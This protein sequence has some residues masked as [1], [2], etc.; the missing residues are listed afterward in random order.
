MEE[1]KYMLQ[2]GVKCIWINTFETNK[3]IDEIKSMTLDLKKAFP[4][5]EYSF[6]LG[7]RKVNMIKSKIIPY[8]EYNAVNLLKHIYELSSGIEKKED[9]L[10]FGGDVSD[11]DKLF[12]NKN[13]IIILKDFNIIIDL[14][15]VK[16]IMKDIF[17]LEGG[18]Y[19]PLIIIS[20]VTKIPDELEKFISVVDYELPNDN[21]I[22]SILESLI[23]TLNNKNNN[24]NINSEEKSKIIKACK[25]LTTQQ[26]I[27]I[28]KL[29]VVKTSKID[30][31]IIYNYKINNIKKINILDF[32]IPKATLND[33]GGNANFKEWVSELKLINTEEAKKFGCKS[34]KGYL[35]LGIP[36]TCKTLSSEI[37]ANEF[38]YPLLK[39]SM[40]KI[41]NSKVGASENNMA[42]ALKI[43]KAMAPCVFMIDEV[44]K[45]LSGIGSSNNS[46][47][48]TM[49]RVIGS[50]LEFLNEDNGIFVVMTSN[51]S[52]QLPPELTRAGRLDT[53][54]YFDLPTAEEREEIIQIHLSK[55]ERTLDSAVLQE[56]T[57]LSENFTGAEI[58][59]IVKNTIK[60]N[61]IRFSN[62]NDKEICVDDVKKAVN[63]I[64]PVYKSYKEK[65]FLL[66]QYATDRARMSSRREYSNK[67]ASI[68][69][70]YTVGR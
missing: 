70:I 53:I 50:V 3:V 26:I 18:N 4:I 44:E 14:P 35:A 62:D 51:D 69:N 67:N 25:G 56:F 39:L 65:I 68:K 12:D 5:Y 10:I 17:E 42:Q 40:D 63:E 30:L 15:D 43:V 2:S 60:H 55:Y 66:Q 1:I 13:N 29:S 28:F 7:I 54:W 47:A 46:D 38:G 61:F 48:G 19:N 45:S 64:I 31:D 49:S 11:D 59:E 34:P 32:I 36:G 33:I 9:E 41:L 58:K 57:E 20:P 8:K 21:E 22:N 37:I 16:K 52:S 6:T 27:E 23:R 24:V